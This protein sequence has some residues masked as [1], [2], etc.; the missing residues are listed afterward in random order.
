[1]PCK[2]ITSQVI[3]K[4]DHQDQ[5]IDFNYTKHTCNKTVG[6]SSKFLSHLPEYNM[7]KILDMSFDNIL[8]TIPHKSN[9]E[10]LLLFLQW[11]AL[12]AIISAY[13]GQESQV[14]RSRHI[15][16]SVEHEPNHVKIVMMIKPPKKNYKIQPC[17]KKID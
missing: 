7:F 13:L 10:K 4:I 9:Q 3:L 11:D 6:D 1:M 5:I 8:N 2:D 14:D 12:Q 16:S 15:I 17:F